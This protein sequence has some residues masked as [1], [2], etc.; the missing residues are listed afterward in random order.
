MNK[1]IVVIGGGTGTFAVLTGLK[2]YP[3]DLSVIVTMADSGGSNRVIRNEFGLL[4]TSDVRQCIVALADESKNELLRKLFTYRYTQGVGI[5]GM[6]FG[7]L[8]MAALADTL[9]SQEAAIQETC[10]LFNVKGNIIP[11][12]YEKSN[13]VA[14]YEDGSVILGEHEIDE[15]DNRNPSRIKKISI[16][17]KVKANPQAQS[18]IKNADWLIIGPGDLYTSIL[19]NLIVT[20][21]TKAIDQ[22]Q[23]KIIYICNLMTRA[24]QTLGF[25]A[26]DHVNQVNH[27][28]GKRKVHYV[29]IHQGNF[30]KKAVNWY[31]LVGATPVS[32]NLTLSKSVHIVRRD[33]VSNEMFQKNKA[34]RLIRS[35]IRHDPIKLGEILYGLLKT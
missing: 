28:L 15:P 33:V 21:I 9:G 11:V 16:F 2:K 35:L 20:G 12:T 3:L 7:N 31:S 30:T 4:P 6:T 22:S 26:L 14:E 23:A 13:L 18:A 19:C 10:R 17:P 8:F 29:L 24:G 32:D 25:T 34:D 27:Y 1:K 5:A